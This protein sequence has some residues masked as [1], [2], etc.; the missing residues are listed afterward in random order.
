M[1]RLAGALEHASE[2]PIGR[3]DRRP[4]PSRS[5]RCPPVADFANARG[6]RRAAALVDG[7]ACSSVGRPL[8]VAEGLTRCRADLAGAMATGAQA[9]G[10]TAVVVG[11]DG[12][13]R[14][15]SWWSPT[16][17]SRPAGGDRPAARARAAP[18]LL[19]GDNAAV[20][21]AVAAEVGIDGR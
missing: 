21:R 18:V 12:A 17:S 15:A 20:A 4:R 8:L 2:H 3:A 19:T 11:W 6:P 9:A 16:R 13:A 10:R 14:G 5:A 7:D 1:L